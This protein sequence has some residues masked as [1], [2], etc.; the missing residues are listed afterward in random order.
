MCEREIEGDEKT[1]PEKKKEKKDTNLKTDIPFED[2]IWWFKK[3]TYT[4]LTN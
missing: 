3:F 2:L 1:N 4:C